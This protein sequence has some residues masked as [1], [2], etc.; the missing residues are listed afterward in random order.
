MERAVWHLAPC[1]N[2]SAA[3]GRLV[4][5]CLAIVLAPFGSNDRRSHFYL[6]AVGLSCVTRAMASLM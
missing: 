3:A 2:H 4:F 6:T 1:S 5:R